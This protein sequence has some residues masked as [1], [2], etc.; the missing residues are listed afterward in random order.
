M[1][2]SKDIFLENNHEQRIGERCLLKLVS[3]SLSCLAGSRRC[4]AANSLSCCSTNVLAIFYLQLHYDSSVLL[5]RLYGQQMSISVYIILN[6]LSG[7]YSEKCCDLPF[8]MFYI[9]ISIFRPF[10]YESLMG[11][12]WTRKGK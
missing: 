12:F 11:V 1:L 10:T 4:L 7:A 2:Y 8:K 3:C 6:K 9:L 5:C